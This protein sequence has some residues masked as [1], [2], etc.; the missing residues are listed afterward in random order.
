MLLG[1]EM[2]SEGW[3]TGSAWCSGW[4]GRWCGG[5]MFSRLACLGSGLCTR[6]DIRRYW[7][8]CRGRDTLGVQRCPIG[9]M[10]PSS[11][12]REGREVPKK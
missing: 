6:S 12:I 8:S 5:G 7:R 4:I 1:V 10:F 9:L 11:F 3:N 2:R